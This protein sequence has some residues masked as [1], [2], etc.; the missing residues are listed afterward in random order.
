MSVTVEQVRLRIAALLRISESRVTLTTVLT[1]VVVES[2]QLVEM[3]FGLLDDF[4]C[5]LGQADLKS[6]NTVADLAQLV[7]A[8]VAEG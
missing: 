3:A 1:D 8:R 5:L 7:Q 2:F 6:I 4:G